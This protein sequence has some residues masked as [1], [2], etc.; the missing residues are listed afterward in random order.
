MSQK[1]TVG[2]ERLATALNSAFDIRVRRLVMEMYLKIL[3]HI[4]HKNERQMIQIG[5]DILM[6]I[7]FM[8]RG[9]VRE[10]FIPQ[11]R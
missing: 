11:E 7:T 9:T 8:R 2:K 5:C 4:W 1:V 3:N 6:F 10:A